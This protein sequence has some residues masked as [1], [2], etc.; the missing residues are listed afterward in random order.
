[1]TNET[2]GK[3][4]VKVKKE[5]S[6]FAD[7][8]GYKFREMKRSKSLYLFLL[9]F[10]VLFITFTVLPVITAIYYSFTY[11]NILEPPKFIFWDNYTRMFV[12][13]DLFMNAFNNTLLF[14]AITGVVGYVL[15]W[16]FAWL[17]NELSPKVRAGMTLIYYAPT[18]ANI[19]VVWKLVFSSD[20]YGLLNGFLRSTGLNMTNIRWLE[21]VN[22]IV[23]SVLVVLLWSSLGV[24]FL[25]FI[26][27]LQNVDRQLYE[28]G[29][30]DG[31][32]NRWQEAW[33]ITLPYMRPML[34][35][36][37]IMQVTGA[38]SIGDQISALV[39]YPSQD[40]VAQTLLLNIQDYGGTRMEMGYACAIAT[41]LF[42]LMLFS[43]MLV[44]KLLRKVGN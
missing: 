7:W 44:Q 42:F 27:G 13:D 10:L 29:A 11:F 5:K 2:A 14:A 21:D 36:G 17:I 20:Q 38:F 15:S 6:F 26:A 43:N 33:Y 40:Y 4:A 9:P 32:R 28:A 22:Y 12:A 41:F 23:P 1:M 18:L 34:M 19:Y 30:I 24:S 39:G 35:F 25:T 31:V 3:T 16:L 8:M 37:A